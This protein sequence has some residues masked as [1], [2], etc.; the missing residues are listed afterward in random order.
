VKTTPGSRTLLASTAHSRERPGLVLVLLLL[1]IQTASSQS[2][3]AGPVSPPLKPG[4][5]QHLTSPDEVPAGLA[6]SEWQSIRAAYE[7]GQHSFQPLGGESGR[8]RARNPG[9]GFTT[10]FDGGGFLATPQAGGWEWGLELKSYGFGDHLKTVERASAVQAEDQGLTYTRDDSLR[11]WFLNDQKGLEHGFTVLQ[12]PLGASSEASGSPLE[13]TLGVRGGLRPHIA[14]DAQGVD[15]KD[16]SGA[17]AITYGGLKVWDKDGKVLASRFEPGA[18]GQRGTFRISVDERGAR[19]PLFIDPLA[20]QAYLRASNPGAGDDFGVSVSVSGDT[21]VVGAFREDSSTTGVNSAPNESASNSGAA[22]VFVRSGTTWTQQA[23]LKASNTGVDDLFGWSVSVS[24][25]TA[26]VGAWGED[27]STTGVNSTPNE[28]ASRSGAAYV[29]VRSGTTWTQQAYLK[30]SNT[31]GID[32]IAI[33]GVGDEFGREVSVSG[34]TVVVGAWQ[35]ASSTTGVNSTPNELAIGSGAAYVFVRSGTTWTQQAY[36]K[37]SNTGASDG[38]GGS[39]SVSGDTVVVGAHQEDSSTTGVNSTPNES[40]SRSGAAYVF[41]RSGTMWTEQAYLKASN[42]G[43]DDLFGYSVSVSGDTVAVGAYGEGA[44]YVF[45]RSGTTWMQQGYLKAGNTGAFGHFGESV[46]VSGDTAVIGAALEYSDTTGPNSGA[47]YVFV[48]SGTTWAQQA[49][50]KGSN[51]EDFFGDSV[52][53]SGDTMVVGA[54]LEDTASESGAAYV[55]SPPDTLPTVTTPTSGSITTT[56]ATLGGTVTPLISPAITE[57]GVVYSLTATN[58]DPLLG[59]FGVTKSTVPGT[60]GPF[61]SEVTGLAT[62]SAYSFKAYATNALGTGYTTVATFTTLAT[63]PGAPTIGVATAS[64]GAVSVAFTAPSSN[65]GSAITGYTATCGT[66]SA[67]GASSP[68]TVTGLTNGTAVTCTVVAT[69]AAGN[70]V[71]SAASNSVTPTVGAGIKTVCA[72]GCGFTRIQDAINASAPGDRVLVKS[73][74]DSIGSGEVFPIQTLAMKG[75]SP[76]G[77]ITI[78]GE[79]DGSGN[80]TTKIKIRNATGL[81]GIMM[82][83]PGVVSDLKIVPGDGTR[84]NRVIAAGSGNTCPGSTCHLKGG[85]TIRNVVIDFTVI[86]GTTAAHFNTE[87]GV[88]LLADDVLI[89]KVTIKGIAGKSIF[90]DG[91]NSTIRNS[92]LDGRDPSNG[93]AIRGTLAIG[94]GADNRVSGAACSGFPT[95]YLIDSNTIVG[96]ADYGIQWCSGRNNTISNNTIT[97]INGWSIYNS[98]SRSTQVFGNILQ[99]NTTTQALIGITFLSNSF[100]TC[101][102]NTVRNNKVL[103]RPLRDMVVGIWVESCVDTTIFQNEVRDVRDDRGAIY[104]SMAAGVP[105][106]TTIQG[107]TV[108]GG[109]GSGIVYFGADSGAT[110]VDQSVIRDNV[111]NEF[112]RNGIVVQFV[113]GVR[114]GAGAGNVV[115]YNTVRAVNLGSYPDTH[116]F[117]LQNLA[118]TAFDRNTALDTRGAG[119]GFFLA[120]STG[121]NGNC[122]TGSTN[123]GG[124]FA[125][126]N[127]TPPYGNVNVNCRAALYSHYDFDGDSKSEVTIYRHTTGQWFMKSSSTGADSAIAFGN[128]G[129]DDIPAPGNYTV[130]GRTDIAIYRYT[131]GEWYIRRA[132]DGGTTVIP[133]GS[134]LVGD[135]PMPADYDGDGLT[136]LAVF[137]TSTANAEWYIRRSSDGQTQYVAWGCAACADVGVPGDYDGDG[138]ADVAVYRRSTGEWFIRKSTDTALQQVPFGDS[139]QG[140]IPVPGRYTQTG[141][142]DMAVYRSLT[143]EWFIR[144]NDFGITSVK[145]GDPSAGDFPVSAD[146]TQAGIT[147]IAIYRPTPP[148]AQFMIRK[149]TDFST[150]TIPYGNPGSQD[151]PLTAR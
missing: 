54:I 45:V 67:S 8:W 117:N 36:L 71:A 46:S 143:G 83:S 115:A 103:G 112:K 34:D 21:V 47:A 84:P 63:V 86:D 7:A 110:A 25:D 107:N 2:K 118:N 135:V 10:T 55:F 88:A 98:G 27:S 72:S 145:F 147:D 62:A 151:A 38:F 44:A 116:A 142:T 136:D 60:T 129:S 122:N 150:R 49:H 85:L 69:N 4:T 78:A 102:G 68:I 9:Q 127:V 59:G 130:A 125:Q 33:Y 53:V 16:A 42:T 124:L 22:Y 131:T 141:R 31:G 1:G 94:F 123:G 134:P 104:A 51:T 89:D 66:Q 81:D 48:R 106:K 35:E 137:R 15:F 24:G 133:F 6:R 39:V 20:Q 11:E 18:D 70:S 109:N 77:T 113:K 12:R 56:T 30:A 119:A 87:N 37:A 132:T 64:N 65:G 61:S 140:D 43:V 93:N 144:S 120:N 26:V 41:V 13:L 79:T 17:T 108:I 23:Y 126:V 96:Y 92:T 50:L 32:P 100:Q 75:Q 139:A 14:V 40:A 146:F 114:S 3:A 58:P 149:S 91:D 105:T 90:V 80:P 73:T 99:N 101:S 138:K 82:V 95:N 97:D 76:A 128:P 52:S 74:Y 28:S 111:V 19:Y 121:V 29:F 5:T 148:T 57:R